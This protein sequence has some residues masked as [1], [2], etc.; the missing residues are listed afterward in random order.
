MNNS[1]L[2]SVED[3]K[4]EKELK[5]KALKQAPTTPLL[6]KRDYFKEQVEDDDE[7]SALQPQSNPFN[8]NLE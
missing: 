8:I 7:I 4:L 2:L 6:Q 1:A 3:I 5:Q